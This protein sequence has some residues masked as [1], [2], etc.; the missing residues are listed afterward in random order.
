MNVVLV[1]YWFDV[2]VL[3]ANVVD[4]P[5]VCSE[6]VYYVS[7]TRTRPRTRSSFTFPYSTTTPD[8]STGKQMN[9]KKV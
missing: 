4:E 7:E 5:F 1:A 3:V 6:P 2:H 8:Q 9:N